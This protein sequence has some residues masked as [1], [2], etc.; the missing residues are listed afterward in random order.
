MKTFRILICLSLVILSFSLELSSMNKR[1]EASTYIAL[2]NS[3]GL[4]YGYKEEAGQQSSF[5]DSY[6]KIYLQID[7]KDIGKDDQT[8]CSYF[9]RRN[10][11]DI[12]INPSWKSSLPTYMKCNDYSCEIPFKVLNNFVYQGNGDNGEFVIQLTDKSVKREFKIIITN[13]ANYVS[14]DTVSVSRCQQEESKFVSLY[15]EKMKEIQEP[16]QRVVLNIED[17]IRTLDV[18]SRDVKEQLDR[19]K[20]ELSNMQRRWKMAEEDKAKI[21]KQLTEVVLKI[22]TRNML[23]NV[24]KS[25]IQKNDND[26]ASAG[27]ALAYHIA[28]IKKKEQDKANLIKKLTEQ[29]NVQI[30]RFFYYLEASYFY[31]VFPTKLIAAQS[32]VENA[33]NKANSDSTKSKIIKAFYPIK[34]QFSAEQVK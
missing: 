9:L 4:K 20:G 11:L 6:F 23:I 25:D 17:V 3:L 28:L 5:D 33:I 24:I 14:N 7:G 29:K 19:L 18:Y 22:S 2:L 32:D 10:Y 15:S 31:R 16:I 26:R 21:D 8:I 27:V 13:V 12:Q 30:E 1:T 34:V